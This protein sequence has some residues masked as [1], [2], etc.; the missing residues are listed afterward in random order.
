MKTS[1]IIQTATRGASTVTFR[2]NYA[3]ATCTV[4]GEGGTDTADLATGLALY[5][6]LARTGWTCT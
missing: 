6:H 5:Q 4:R 2:F 3:A 1:N